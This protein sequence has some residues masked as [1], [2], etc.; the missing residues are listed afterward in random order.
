MAQSIV[1]EPKGMEN[2]SAKQRPSRALEHEQDDCPHDGPD[3]LE[4]LEPE[5]PRKFPMEEY[6][7]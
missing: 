1:L 4:K 5:W 2:I 6:S 3:Q 7:I